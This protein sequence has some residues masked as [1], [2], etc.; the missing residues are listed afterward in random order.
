MYQI[1]LRCDGTP[2]KRVLEAAIEAVVRANVVW[3]LEAWQAGD[4]PPCCL[5]CGEVRYL[6]DR[7]SRR[8]G[9]RGAADVLNSGHASCQ[10]AAAYQSAMHRAKGL[11]EHGMT[12]DEVETA[13]FVDLE[14]RTH[15]RA[16]DGYWHAVSVV[17]GG[18]ED[19]TEEMPR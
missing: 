17:D 12:L 18:R 19:V 15:A 6:P 5:G 4:D 10:E 13:Y 14:P 2:D 16:P 9:V 1:D 3:I 11:V 7:P 8:V